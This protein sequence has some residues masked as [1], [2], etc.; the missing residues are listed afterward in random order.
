MTECVCT[1]AGWCNR[2]KLQK[3]QAWVALC[4]SRP[5]YFSLW[6]AGSGPGNPIN[7]QIAIAQAYYKFQRA[8]ALWSELHS[9]DHPTESWFA[10][11]VSRV[12]NFG[13]GCRAWLRDYLVTNPPR[14]SDWY[15][16]TVE[17]HNAVNVK[18]GKPLFSQE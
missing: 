2:H 8:T 17:L 18:L 15:P 7:P 11:W 9:Q 13:C 3:S 5:D 10:A 12:P 6:D 1:V 4:Q 16:W 14:Y